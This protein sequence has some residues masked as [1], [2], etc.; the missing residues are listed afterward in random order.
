MSSSTNIDDLPKEMIERI[1]DHLTYEDRVNLANTHPNLRFMMPWEQI[2]EVDSTT[3]NNGGY[4]DVPVQSRG[5]IDIKMSGHIRPIL[6]QGFV[7]Q[8]I[9]DGSVIGSKYPDWHYQD[10]NWRTSYMVLSNEV[11]REARKGDILRL[12]VLLESRANHRNIIM[13]IR[14]KYEI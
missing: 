1:G 3:L 13:R 11:V 12:T 8:L 6:A 5:L 10:G 7:I 14:H 9:R 2:I 4:L